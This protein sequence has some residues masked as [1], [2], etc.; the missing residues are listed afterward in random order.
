MEMF[1]QID[2]LITVMFCFFLYYNWVVCD[3][4]YLRHHFQWTILK[5]MPQA[6][7]I[8]SS[9]PWFAVDKNVNNKPCNV[10]W[11]IIY[12]L[13]PPLGLHVCI[14]TNYFVYSCSISLVYLKR[15]FL[16]V[17]SINSHCMACYSHFCLQRILLLENALSRI[18]E[19][20]IVYTLMRI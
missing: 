10:N 7:N 18:T 4:M 19:S 6:A 2:I 15:G 1:I 12:S 13:L 5:A 17:F 20:E 3:T 8:V 9:N 16:I 14:I 11:Y